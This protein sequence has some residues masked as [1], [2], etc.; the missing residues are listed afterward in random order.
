M[1]L[2]TR[3]LV[4]SSVFL[5]TLPVLAYYFIEK[6]E[7]SLLQGQEEV[8]S[9]TASA[10][11]TVVKGYTDLFDVDEDA[12]Y[13]YP[14]ELGL[15][16]DGYI[17]EDEDWYRLKEKFTSYDDYLS[18]LLI[19][20]TQYVYAYLRVNDPDIIYRNPRYKS[21]DSSDHIRLEYLDQD[22]QRRR[23]VLLAEGQG[24]VSVYEV[25][26]D[27]KIWKNGRHVNAVYAIWRETSAGYDIELHFPSKWLQ[28]ARRLSLS[29]FDVFGENERY[30]DTIISTQILGNDI[31]NPL[32]FR[33]K[34]ISSA[35]E[36]LKDS[37]S[38]ICVID[39]FRRVRAVIGG[40]LIS[41]SLCQAT[42]KVSKM[43]V[44]NVLLGNQQLQTIEAYFENRYLK[45]YDRAS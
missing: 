34:K 45:S 6:I 22:G 17:S 10:L 41:D 37:T 29:V 33:S 31:L 36:G 11:A 8:Q 23:L 28:P 12:L 16:L 9:M 27:W 5:L 13:V 1:R 44:E 40:H 42:D 15:T 20:N 7:S 19:E 26:D 18:L 14:K 24:N 39:K 43:L 30:P 3:L 35:I 32:L 21:L 25:N 2:G 38:Q 4:F